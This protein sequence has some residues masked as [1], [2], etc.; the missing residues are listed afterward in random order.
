MV[1]KGALLLATSA[2]LVRSIGC[3]RVWLAI[4]ANYLSRL[5]LDRG[6]VAAIKGYAAEH[7]DEL[8][9]QFLDGLGPK[10]DLLGHVL[11]R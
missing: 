11:S 10:T 1:L 9:E 3:A 6:R 4:P 2:A 8:A 5:D 7:M